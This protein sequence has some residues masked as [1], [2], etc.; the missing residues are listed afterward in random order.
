MQLENKN[1]NRNNATMKNEKQSESNNNK[2]GATI[3]G[4]DHDIKRDT[5]VQLFAFT[6]SAYYLLGLLYIVILILTK[7]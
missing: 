6:P 5:A 4:G 3:N 1:S 2:K 7:K